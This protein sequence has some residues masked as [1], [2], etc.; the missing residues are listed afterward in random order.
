MNYNAR[1]IDALLKGT[2]R[3]ESGVLLLDE[4]DPMMLR[5]IDKLI[6]LARIGAEVIATKCGW[7]TRNE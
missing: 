2:V 3:L 5:Q 4:G 6:W 7:R 1:L